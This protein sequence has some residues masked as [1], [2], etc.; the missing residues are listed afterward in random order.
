M[1]QNL[2]WINIADN[3]GVKEAMI[4]RVLGGSNQ[5]T[6]NVGDIVVCSAKT[7]IP[8]STIKKGQV[9]K[10]VIVRSK[11]GVK[12]I[13]GTCV[14]FDDNAAVIIKEDKTPRAT[15]VFGALAR[16]VKDSGFSKIASLA[17]EIV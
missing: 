1:L 9:I 14:K 8:S 5:K 4:I 12:R 17:E 10:A 15:R 7:V 6:A 13:D 2:S 11:F 16:E 3:S